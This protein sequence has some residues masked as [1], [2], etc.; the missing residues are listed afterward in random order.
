MLFIRIRL[1]GEVHLRGK[2]PLK[3]C[4]PGGRGTT[5]CSHTSAERVTSAP[6]QAAG[7]EGTQAGARQLDRAPT[8][9]KR[10]MAS[11]LLLRSLGTEGMLLDQHPAG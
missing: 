6:D 7:D 2:F 10:R 1:E 3:V 11:R 5:H 9:S 8:H 4:V